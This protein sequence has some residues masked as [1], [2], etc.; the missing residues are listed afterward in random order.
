VRRWLPLDQAPSLQRS[1]SDK[2]GTQNPRLKWREWES[3]QV[4]FLMWDPGRPVITKLYGTE[5]YEV[6]GTT[7]I[8]FLPSA[9]HPCRHWS[10][11]F[12]ILFIESD[13]EK[14]HFVPQGKIHPMYFDIIN[15]QRIK[16][17][18]CRLT[19]T[20]FCSMGSTSWIQRLS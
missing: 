4:R 13:H 8:P 19:Y 16:I 5:L 15:P 12:S 17:I 7:S 18:W 11:L 20:G 3:Y 10:W 14:V 1:C 2:F 9:T 6:N